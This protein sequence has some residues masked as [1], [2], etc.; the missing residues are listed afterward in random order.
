MRRWLIGRAASAVVAVVAVGQLALGGAAG[1]SSIAT[2]EDLAWQTPFV[3]QNVDGSSATAVQVQFV[4]VNSGN[5]AKSV[6][7]GPLAAGRSVAVR[8]HSYTDLASGKYSVVVSSDAKISAIVNQSSGRLNGSYLGLSSLRA[9]GSSV[10][11][12]NVVRNYAG[13][14]SPLYVQNAGNAAT[15]VTV[16]FYRFDSGAQAAQ[17]SKTLQPGQTYE[18][19]PAATAGLADGTQYSVVASSSGQPLAGMVNQIRSGNVVMTYSGFSSGGTTVYLPNITR[20]YAEW[21]TPF[22]VQNVGAATTQVTARYYRFA[23][24]AEVKVD[25][26]YD[27]GVGLSR[28]FRPHGTSGLADGT[29]YSVVVQSSGQPIVALVNEDSGSESM[30]Y[31]GFSSGGTTVYLPN[32]TRNYAEW[33]TP[34]I[35]QNVG[36]ATTQVTARYYRFADGAEVK[37]DGPYDLGVGLS[38]PFRPH[39]TSGLADGTQYSVVVQSSGQP[40]VALVNQHHSSGDAMAYEGFSPAN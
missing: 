1:V 30:S 8:P 33:N 23:D 22:I 14:N 40:I 15:A 7:L 10:S 20:N 24:G 38:R 4:D 5:V 9:S 39:G 17:V 35:V 31:S 26:P 16:T 28:P 3:I 27:L 2:A 37:V 11:F 13:W 29:Q 36:A 34:F 25:G 18:V 6:D 12:P 21:N 19:N 32:I